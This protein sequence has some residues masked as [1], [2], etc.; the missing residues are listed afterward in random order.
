MYLD[1]RIGGLTGRLG[2]SQLRIECSDLSM[3]ALPLP[4]S[5]APH[6]QSVDL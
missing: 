5:L 2:L 4:L 3:K 6:L 1:L